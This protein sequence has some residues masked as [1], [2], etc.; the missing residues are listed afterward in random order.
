[1]VE[2]I[3]VSRRS[4]FRHFFVRGLGVLLPTILTL[5]ILSAAY[6]FLQNRIAQPINDG[7]QWTVLEFTGF[8]EVTSAEVEQARSTLP[9]PEQRNDK[10]AT[11][12]ARET[13]LTRWWHSGYQG[14]VM[15][16][17][18]LVVAIILVYLAGR[19][20]TSFIGRPLLYATEA[21]LLRVPVVK[22]IYPAVKQVTDLFVGA[23]DD[24]K[25]KFNR[26]IAVEFPRKD[27][28]TLA[29]VTAETLRPLQ[30]HVGESMVT[31]FVPNTPTP[32]TGFVIMV[33]RRDVFDLPLS[34]DDAIKFIV[35][36]G[37]VVPPAHMMPSRRSDEAERPQPQIVG[38]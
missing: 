30:E 20:L 19:L 14:Y 17:I 11:R 9:V 29:F 13:S 34:I 3:S 31:V 38:K 2:V 32:L 25:A 1:M 18:G 22:Q 37:V 5:W 33:P 35:S 4:G 21:L 24:A 23:P 12:V 26:V 36:A 15:N 27:A 8:P 6:G 7:I 28:W 10:L 16:Q